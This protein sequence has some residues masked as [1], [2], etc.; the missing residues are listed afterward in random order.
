MIAAEDIKEIAYALGADLC[1]IAPVGR[2]ND[3]P[4]GFKPKDIYKATRSVIVYAKRL[5]T[6]IL[7]AQSCIPYTH[8]NALI[9]T[10][11]DRLSLSLSLKLQDR[12][13]KNVIVPTDDPY[14]FWDGK[15]RHG[16]GILSMR[17]AGYLAGLGRLGKN[18]LLINK[19]YG[20]MIQIGVILADY[21]C[22]YDEPA[23]YEVCPQH[24]SA[25]LSVCPEEALDGTTVQQS[26]CRELS[27]FKTEQG[28]VLKK[29]WAC[30]SA[31]PN[32]TGLK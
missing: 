13:I 26:R 3:A 2:F 5:P 32:A 18:N 6:E 30:R 17:H 24:C 22:E 27:N 19:T 4:S 31:C 15:K 8:V 21:E 28:F 10:E 23:I 12:G 1:G 14:E 16:M 9:A 7:F 25:C 11:V 29:C 20:N